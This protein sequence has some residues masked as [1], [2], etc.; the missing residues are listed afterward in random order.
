MPRAVCIHHGQSEAGFF[1]THGSGTVYIETGLA[2]SGVT[3]FSA[4]K[5]QVETRLPLWTWSNLGGLSSPITMVG[6]TSFVSQWIDPRITPGDD[7]PISSNTDARIVGK[8]AETFFNSVDTIITAENATTD[9][10]FSDWFRQTFEANDDAGWVFN[11]VE[12]ARAI[13]LFMNYLGS[14]F[15]AT[16]KPYFL[17]SVQ[18]GSTNHANTSGLRSNYARMREIQQHLA[19]N[20]RRS[21]R[22]GLG[23]FAVLPN[24]RIIASA[25]DHVMFAH[26]ETADNVTVSTPADFLHQSAA[27][28]RRTAKQMAATIAKLLDA[29]TPQEFDG[30]PVIDRVSRVLGDPTRI[31]VVV[32][33]T[34]GNTLRWEG[35][36]AEDTDLLVNCGGT[37]EPTLG[38]FLVHTTSITSGALPS[39]V[40]LASATI[41][42]GA[43]AGYAWFDVVLADTVPATCYYT[44]TPGRTAIG[45]YTRRAEA[46]SPT[47]KRKTGLYEVNND[48]LVMNAD[49]SDL[50]DTPNDPAMFVLAAT[51]LLVGAAESFSPAPSI[52]GFS[53]DGL[54]L[55]ARAGFASSKPTRPTEWHLAIGTGFT[56]VGG[57]VGQVGS[58]VNTGAWTVTGST[59][60]NPAA[61]SFASSAA[62][63]HWA[64]YTAATGGTAIAGGALTITGGLAVNAGAFSIALSGATAYLRNLLLR[65]AFTAESVTLP[66]G[67]H[68]A[69]GTGATDTEISGQAGSRA[70][71][72]PSVTGGVV[73]FGAPYTV[74]IAADAGS[75]TS[76]GVYDAASGG[77]MLALISQDGVATGEA[78]TI[79]V[80]TGGTVTLS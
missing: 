77:N 80:A 50:K 30:P 16:S 48:A 44:H 70:T 51:N 71:A 69:V 66:T 61:D 74:S 37:T 46:I 40:S 47:L 26:A 13:T 65:W 19:V 62:C 79:T 15:A 58:R 28:S 20:G 22:A 49:A 3:G 75:V 27:S 54:N 9:V 34:A 57:I 7:T 78:G 32:K 25:T 41:T 76:V 29:E 21:S 67:W 43:P 55:L 68:V 17:C 1:S 5:T 56:S 12:Y 14:K 31:R 52:T 11:D 6:G 23:A 45:Y 73:T 33:I 36:A 35:K 18:P 53:A 8:H 4:L 2:G 72:T 39:L 42:P 63:T 60:T 38:H 24:Y 64:L 10:W 59:A